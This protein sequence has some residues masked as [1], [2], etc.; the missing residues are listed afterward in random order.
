[1]PVGAIQLYPVALPLPTLVSW[2]GRAIRLF[3]QQCWSSWGLTP[4]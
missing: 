1:M 4:E 2:A 3:V